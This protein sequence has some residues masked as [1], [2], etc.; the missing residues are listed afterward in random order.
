M[1][2]KDITAGD[3]VG[4]LVAARFIKSSGGTPGMELIFS[5]IEPSTSKEERM[6]Y[7]SW[8]SEKSV[9]FS[10]DMLV[11]VLGYNGSQVTDAA[12]VLTDPAAFTYTRQVKLV[13]E[14]EE[15]QDKEGATKRSPKIK[16]INALGGSKFEN[17]SPTTIKSDLDKIGFRA[18]FLAA[19]Q[20]AGGGNQKPPPTRATFD[21]DEIPF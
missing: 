13:I 16:Y 15:Y 18:A 11:N 8:L 1:S 4:T 17:L 7:Q 19:T 6:T 9:K 5:F 21:S 2:Y 12:G 10:M 20:S 3:R 14:Q